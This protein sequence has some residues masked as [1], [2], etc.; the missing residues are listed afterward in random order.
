MKHKYFDFLFF[1]KYAHIQ[2]CHKISNFRLKKP[3][4]MGN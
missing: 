2:F 1:K 3:G 4:S